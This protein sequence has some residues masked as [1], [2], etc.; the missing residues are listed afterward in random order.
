MKETTERN[1]LPTLGM[2]ALLLLVLLA[3]ARAVS[4]VASFLATDIRYSETL[5]P[6]ILNAAKQLL[7]VTAFGSGI[8]LLTL[9]SR[10]GKRPLWQGVGTATALFLLDGVASFAIDATSGAVGKELLP[11][12][13]IYCGMNWLFHVVL[14]LFVAALSD[15][16]RQGGQ[17]RNRILLSGALVYMGG[18]LLLETL[19]LVQFLIEVEFMPY[20][21]EILSILLAYG[22]IVLLY[23]GVGFLSA[24]LF[25]RWLFPEKGQNGTKP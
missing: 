9:L 11:V 2:G 5:W 14:L 15:R 25:S 10:F 24:V 7:F 12:A 13:A 21:R 1:G 20:A 22:E 8:S 4:V 17:N 18:R 23:G 3:A 6:V 16:G 19:Y